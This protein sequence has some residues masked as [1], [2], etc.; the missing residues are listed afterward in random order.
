MLLFGLQAE[1]MTSFHET[2]LLL[3]KP[4]DRETTVI[5]TWVFG[6]YFLK[7]EHSEPASSKIKIDNT[8]HQ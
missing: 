5:Q 3:Q 4:T 8:Y 1:P 2:P 6:Q 7:N